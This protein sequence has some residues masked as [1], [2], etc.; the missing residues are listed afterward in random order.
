VGD[1]DECHYC[2][3]GVS[4][5]E[6]RNIITKIKIEEVMICAEDGPRQMTDDDLNRLLES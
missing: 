2:V 1:G 3:K 5:R 4:E 6:G